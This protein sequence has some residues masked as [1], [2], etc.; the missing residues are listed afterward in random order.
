MLSEALVS[1][2]KISDSNHMT[3]LN[4]VQTMTMY[5]TFG[6]LQEEQPQKIL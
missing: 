2:T 6:D 1:D 3:N 5:F 4:T